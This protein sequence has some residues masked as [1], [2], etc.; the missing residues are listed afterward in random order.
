VDFPEYTNKLAQSYLGLTMDQLK[1]VYKYNFNETIHPSDFPDFVK[2]WTEAFGKAVTLTAEF[3]IKRASD[4]SYRWA[5]MRSVPGV[6]ESLFLPHYLVLCYRYIAYPLPFRSFSY[7]CHR[8]RA[9][10]IRYLKLFS[11]G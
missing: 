6:C 1:L 3:R 5:M 2:A 7:V 10:R 11:C 8:S 9:L 4:N